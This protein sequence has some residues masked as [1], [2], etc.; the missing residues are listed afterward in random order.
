[1]GVEESRV[2]R[3]DHQI[4]PYCPFTLGFNISLK[5][6]DMDCNTLTTQVLYPTIQK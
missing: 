2:P 4:L 5:Y 1:M 3:G 6:G